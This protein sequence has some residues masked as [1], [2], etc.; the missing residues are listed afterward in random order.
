MNTQE[1]KKQKKLAERIAY[2][3]K[4]RRFVRNVLDMTL[5]MSDFLESISGKKDVKQILQATEKRIKKIIPFET[6]VLYRINEEDNPDFIPVVYDPDQFERYV[7]N[8]MEFMIDEGFFAWALRERRGVTISS[9]D[10]TRQ[11][12]LHVIFTPSRIR[13]MFVGLLPAK[14]P[15]I[16]DYSDALLSII[17]MNTA[18]ALESTQLYKMVFNKNMVLEG[19]VKKKT[20]KLMRAERKLL[21][22]QKMEAIGTLAGGV[23]HDLNNIL[24]GL[25][26]YPDLLLMDLSEDSPLRD[27]ILTIKESGEKAATVV[28]DLLTMTRRGVAVTKVLNLNE[29][30]SEYFKSPEY[31]ELKSY[32][33]DVEVKTCFDSNL[34]EI[35]GSPVHLS[36]IVM[37]LVSNAAEALPEGGR[38]TIT[39]QNRYIDMPVGSY[40]DVKEDDYVVLTVSDNGTG[41]SPEDLERIFEPF[42]TKKVMGRSG[43]GLGMAIVWGTVKDHKGYIDIESIEG[44]G[45]IFTLYF[46]VTRQKIEKDTA[47]L[48]IKD[49]MG[50]GESILVVDDMEEQRY[51]AK[52]F[53]KKLGYSVT[54]VASG[55]EAVDYMKNRSSDLLV[56]DMIM[57][58]GIDGLE[59]YKRILK[60]HP[61]QKAIITS[62]F[63]ET[64][65]VKE[66]QKLGAGSYVNKPY[67]LEKIGIAVK[68]ELEKK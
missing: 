25:V 19:E 50:N 61:G 28:Q 63:S 22:A 51:V 35:L 11:F 43:T 3:E 37:N 6:C 34:L 21:H 67:M 32:H 27:P 4:N 59:T 33:P 53:L 31:N 18:N 17:L 41:I 44:K 2:L 20:E 12:V 9:K 14:K 55:E 57:E 54:T 58:P 47:I 64:D 52:G 62:G 8:E 66:A 49:Y 13:G 38:I 26:S 40:D 56:L 16:A 39:T 36:K 29:I 10:N 24:A 7:K 5:S 46:P 30:I 60:L 45:T 68:K 23:A 1:N 48:F 42:Y 15:V 65:R